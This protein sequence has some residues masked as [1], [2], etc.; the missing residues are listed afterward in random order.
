[1]WKI[2]LAR[3][4]YTAM[5]RPISHLSAALLIF[6][7]VA[8]LPFPILARQ[9][10]GTRGGGVR[11]KDDAGRD[12]PLYK[13]SHALLIGIS[14]YDNGWDDLSGVKEDIPAVKRAL[15]RH[16]FEVEV[17]ENLT[18][19]QLEA[20]IKKF[21]RKYGEEHN[22]RLLIYFAGHGHTIIT[23]RGVKLGY[24][25]PRDAPRPSTDMG[26]FKEVAVSMSA[27]ED[28]ALQIESKHALFVFDSCFAGTIFDITRAAH[29]PVIVNM[30]GQPVRQFITAGGADEVV[31]NR[32]VFREQFVEGL[33]GAADLDGDGYITG[34]ELG[35]FLKVK[36]SNYTK[37]AQT[38]QWG[39]LRNSKLDKGDFVFQL[40]IMPVVKS[41]SGRIAGT[42][43][44]PPPIATS[45]TTTTTGIRPGVF[46]F[47]LSVKGDIGEDPEDY[48]YD[49]DCVGEYRLDSNSIRLTITRMTLRAVSGRAAG[50][51]E[52][53]SIRFGLGID[54][55]NDREWKLLNASRAYSINM[56]LTPGE[57]YSQTDVTYSIPI[58]GATDLPRGPLVLEMK[59]RPLGKKDTTINIY[60]YNS[61]GLFTNQRATSDEGGGG[62]AV[63]VIPRKPDEEHSTSPPPIPHGPKDLK[64]HTVY[65][66]GA[67]KTELVL[68]ALAVESNND[69]WLRQTVSK[70]TKDLTT[71]GSHAWDDRWYYWRLQDDAFLL[72]TWAT[73]KAQGWVLVQKDKG[74]WWYK[75][76]NGQWK[77]IK[78]GESE[79]VYWMVEGS[80]VSI[81]IE[82]LPENTPGWLSNDI[83]YKFGQ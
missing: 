17:E 50:P 12:V 2:N 65:T 77:H 36:V 22:N 49:V 79:D 6:T 14:E 75:T 3:D 10:E 11:A 4:E 7:T 33:G 66:V 19:Q 45:G 47:T 9:E 83:K 74:S 55:S 60:V 70:V 42:K 69:E 43:P 30:V 71:S 26:K 27:V 52:L 40:G 57:V 76:N 73:P 78:N 21:I 5:N 34:S 18:G 81:A 46:P 48:D 28:Y 32:S 23:S 35:M 20:A 16:S 67:N 59:T 15:E 61:A 29:P 25:V 8:L 68:R 64:P 51:Q 63:G 72:L 38:P 62:A 80:K 53:V 13:E 44:S 31:P 1:M 56:M 58:N 24:L 37:G 39:T 54:K 82:A 41:N